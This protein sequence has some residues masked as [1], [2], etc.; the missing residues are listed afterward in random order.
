MQGLLLIKN[1]SR[2]P[3]KLKNTR[4][5]ENW[6]MF[7]KKNKIDPL[8]GC[9]QFIKLRKEFNVVII[10]VDNLDQFKQIIKFFNEDKIIDYPKILNKYKYS[11]I[12]KW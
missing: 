6:H 11:N 1:K 2:I 9:I 3:K 10:G 4:F 5:L 7:L 12:S 8:E